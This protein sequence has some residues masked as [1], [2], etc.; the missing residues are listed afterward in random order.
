MSA[1]RKFDW[2]L[3]L[4][5]PNPKETEENELIVTNGLGMKSGL[6]HAK[7]AK[8]G[9]NPTD[10][11][12]SKSSRA[13]VVATHAPDY[14]L[15]AEA[16]RLHALDVA[17]LHAMLTHANFSVAIKSRPGRRPASCCGHVSGKE[18]GSSWSR[19]R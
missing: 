4:N 2:I 9:D 17:S 19:G 1:L 16:Q 18:P 3:L 11:Q 12:L 10:T 7:A 5:S 14:L 6:G 13:K 15:W 8:Y